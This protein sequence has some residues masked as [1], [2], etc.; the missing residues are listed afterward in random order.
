MKDSKGR[1]YLFKL[2]GLPSGFSSNPYPTPEERKAANSKFIDC[3]G[4]TGQVLNW[5]QTVYPYNQ[6]N[7]TDPRA[8]LNYY[9]VMGAPPPLDTE[10]HGVL[11]RF[12]D[13]RKD[14]RH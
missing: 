13:S 2:K 8:A 3:A 6:I 4:N 7:P 5:C 1:V 11:A 10:R 12:L 9:V 14:D